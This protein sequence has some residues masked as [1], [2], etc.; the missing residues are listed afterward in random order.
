MVKIKY[1][2]EVS[3]QKYKLEVDSYNHMIGKV[4]TDYFPILKKI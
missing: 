1:T 3:Y 2:A 4:D